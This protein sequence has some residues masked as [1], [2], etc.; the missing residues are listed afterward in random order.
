MHP[1][2]GLVATLRSDQGATL[3]VFALVDQPAAPSAMVVLRRALILDADYYET[4]IFSRDGRYLAIRGNAYE[5]SLDVFEFPPLDRVLSTTLGEPS[6][7]YPY[8]PEWVE[9]MMAWSRHNIAF[10]A[11]PGVLWVGKPTGELLEVD[12][13]GKH[14]AKHDVLPGSRVTALAA[15]ATGELV[16]AGSAGDLVVVAAPAETAGA[17]SRS[18]VTAFV[19]STEEAADDELVVTDGERTWAP[20]DL[21]TLTVAEDSDPMWLRHRAGINKALGRIDS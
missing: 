21:A 16:V 1:T 7:G 6:P 18:L 4:P 14:V 15:T 8:P 9:R 3:G 11:Q 10:G 12:L 19:D 17:S 2:G 5:N 13:A 20:E